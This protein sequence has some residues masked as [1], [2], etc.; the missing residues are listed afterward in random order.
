M[1]NF[2]RFIKIGDDRLNAEEIVSYGINLDEDDDRYLYIE[3]KTSEDVFQYYEEDV[4]FDLEEK[5]QELDNLLL[6][7]PLGHVD[8]DK[9]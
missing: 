4:D 2:K 6:I 1:E 9:E 3:T 8:F 5:L 7:R